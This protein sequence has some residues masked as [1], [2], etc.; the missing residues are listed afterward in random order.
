[1]DKEKVIDYE[2]DDPGETRGDE[3]PQPPQETIDAHQRLNNDL[4]RYGVED[5]ISRDESEEEK[6]FDKVIKSNNVKQW[7]FWGLTAV[8]VIL[9]ILDIA[10]GIG[11]LDKWVYLFGVLTAYEANESRE[12]NIITK[13]YRDTRRKARNIVKSVL[14]FKDS[15]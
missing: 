12:Q 6:K 14:R 10:F 4:A 2:V 1:M 9:A 8:I 13:E 15:V 7:L 3:T 5:F 11:K